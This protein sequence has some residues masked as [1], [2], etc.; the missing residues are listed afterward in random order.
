MRLRRIL[1]SAALI[2]LALAMTQAVRSP[3]PVACVAPTLP[4][5]SSLI[6]A[7]SVLA[8][9]YFD[10]LTILSTSNGGTAF[11]GGPKVSIDIFGQVISRVWK[12]LANRHEPELCK[13][14][15]AQSFTDDAPNHYGG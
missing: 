7:D 15:A 14:Q 5:A 1:T 12:H 13:S 8:S 9:A 3:D 6:A 10:T 11:F 4:V 2:S